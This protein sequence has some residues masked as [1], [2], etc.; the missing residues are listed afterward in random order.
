MYH[1]ILLP[2]FHRQLKPYIKKHPGLREAIINII[3]HFD[4]RQHDDLGNGVYKVRLSTE[5]LQRG[6]SKSFRL[7]ILLI[8]VKSMIVPITIYFKGDTAT[9]TKREI[10]HQLAQILFELKISRQL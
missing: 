6:K 7:I 4:K 9:I 5:T 3:E 2:Y 1:L 8:E 10:N